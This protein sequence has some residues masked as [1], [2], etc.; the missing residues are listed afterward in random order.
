[1]TNT[2]QCCAILVASLLTNLP[3]HADYITRIWLTHPTRDASTLMVNWETDTPGPSRVEYGPA[4]SLG[5]QCASDAPV[6]LHHVEIPF[7]AEG[8]LHYRVSTGSQCSAIH[9]VK[10]YSGELLRIAVAA[11]WQD[12]PRLDGLLSDDPHLLLSCGDLIAGL[13]RLDQPGDYNNT[14]PFSRL[15]DAYPALFAQTPFMPVLGNHDRQ[16]YYRLLQPPPEPVYDL[17]A[18]AFLRFFPLPE[19]GRTWCLDIL[20]FDVRILGLDLSHTPNAG[21]TWQSCQA[22]DTGSAQFTWYRD[23][24]ASSHQRFVITAYNEWHHLVG[25]LAGGEWM[26]LIRQGSV[27]VSGFGLFAE[28]ADFEGLPCFNTALK[29]GEIYSNGARTRFYQK[30]PSYLLFSIPKSGG[31]MV[32]DFKSLDG[33]RMNQSEW[34]GREN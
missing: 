22:F 15:I 2:L 23:T 11:D 30:T 18:T 8:I 16:I 24:M 32:A 27:A 9:T 7:P 25:K 6:I 12:Q 17:K 4:E 10:S 31:P 21:T 14:A 13:M 26:K 29:T 1:M 19:P 34:P 28:R 20:A 5:H 33:K 3:A